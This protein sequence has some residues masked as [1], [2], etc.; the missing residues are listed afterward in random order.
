MAHQINLY[1]PILLAPRRHFSALA[2]AQSLGLLV[3][4]L[5]ITSGWMALSDARL[6][7]EAIPLLRDPDPHASLPDR[8]AALD[9]REAKSAAD[10]GQSQAENGQCRG[11]SMRWDDFGQHGV[12][13]CSP[14]H[15]SDTEQQINA[16]SMGD[17]KV[18]QL[19]SFA[20][21]P[22]VKTQARG[23]GKQTP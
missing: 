14:P 19:P 15:G 22:Q 17:Y 1:N 3:A 23:Q 16:H 5:A 2:M 9:T 21:W 7:R 6:R 11:P 4:V 20:R 8:I 13:R 12:D 18:A 10:H